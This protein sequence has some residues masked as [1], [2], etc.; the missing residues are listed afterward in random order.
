MIN[1]FDESKN[2]SYKNERNVKK[3]MKF[4]KKDFFSLSSPRW[5]QGYFHD[6]ATHFQVPGPAYYN[7]KIQ[8]TKK[9]FNLNNKDFIYTNSLP[10]KNDDY[11][12]NSSVL[13]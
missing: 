7:P 10:F 5:D 9:S 1:G 12:S 3:L 11:Y 8:N 6:N 4:K 13:I 2:K